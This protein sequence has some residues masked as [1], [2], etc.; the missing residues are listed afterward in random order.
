MYEITEFSMKTFWNTLKCALSQ[1]SKQRFTFPCKHSS[2]NLSVTAW[3]HQ[4]G[5]AEV[6]SLPRL[7][8]CWEGWTM[9]RP[10]G[11]T[12]SWSPSK[13]GRGC[14]KP[15]LRWERPG[16]I[17]CGRYYLLI[18]VYLLK[19]CCYSEFPIINYIICL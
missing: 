3:A 12:S 8:C 14:R 11:G 10:P 7:S 13:C 18:S 2:M 9:L 5:Q 16:S 15:G 19:T 1:S 6:S 17:V 4:Q